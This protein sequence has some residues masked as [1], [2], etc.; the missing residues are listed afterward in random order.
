MQLDEK[1]SNKSRK[2]LSCSCLIS[3]YLFDSFAFKEIDV[4]QRIFG[5]LQQ[6]YESSDGSLEFHKVLR[7]FGVGRWR[8]RLLLL[9]LQLIGSRSAGGEW[10]IGCGC[11]QCATHSIC[12]Q[13]AA[14]PNPNSS[15][16]AICGRWWWCG[17]DAATIGGTRLSSIRFE[18]HETV[19]DA[20][21][22]RLVHD[23]AHPH[24]MLQGMAKL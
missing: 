18:L 13:W 10:A 1:V 24:D 12:G 19:T 5:V 16:S 11:G 7:L 2:D 23:A 8:R 15:C 17:H 9:L 4:Q 22:L 20:L 6:V 14:N 21:R 3:T